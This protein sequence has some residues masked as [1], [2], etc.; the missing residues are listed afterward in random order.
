M[1][2]A[3]VQ[4][5]ETFRLQ[6][7]RIRVAVGPKG[8]S[9]VSFSRAAIFFVEGDFGDLDNWNHCA[10]PFLCRLAFDRDDL[11]LF[12]RHACL[13]IYDLGLG[14]GLLIPTSISASF[15]TVSSTPIS[16]CSSTMASR[17]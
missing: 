1:R 4:Q 6:D 17:S 13:C 8:L 7:F 2:Q 9:G 16:T 10:S 12:D 11:Y 5:F 3:V 14:L 15:T